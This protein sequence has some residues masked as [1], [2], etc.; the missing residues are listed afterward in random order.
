LANGSGASWFSAIPLAVW[1]MVRS[2]WGI[3]FLVIAFAL[4]S[5]WSRRW[6]GVTALVALVGVV[7]GTAATAD[8]GHGRAAELLSGSPASL[9]GR[10][11]SN[12]GQWFGSP[13]W[14]VLLLGA[15]FALAVLPSVR[16]TVTAQLEAGTVGGVSGLFGTSTGSRGR[17]EVEDWTAVLAVAHMAVL[18]GL[19]VSVWMGLQRISAVADTASCLG[20]PDI[21]VA[22]FRPVWHLSYFLVGLALGV[23]TV[24]NQKSYR[25]VG[26]RGGEQT[27][28]TFGGL[29]GPILLAL[30]VPAG[31][32]LFLLS[33]VLLVGSATALVGRRAAAEIQERRRDERRRKLARARAVEKRRGLR[34]RQEQERRADLERRKSEKEAQGRH[35]ESRDPAAREGKPPAG[36]EC[37]CD[38]CWMDRVDE[39][40]RRREQ[41]RP[42]TE[43][44]EPRPKKDPDVEPPAPPSGETVFASDPVGETQFDSGATDPASDPDL[45]YQSRRPLVDLLPVGSAMHLLLHEDGALSRWHSDRIEAIPGTLLKK[46]LGLASGR[47]DEMIAA[48]GANRLLKVSV[49][50]D[51]GPRISEN[52][53]DLTIG[54]F[55]VNPFGTIVAY[56]PL[57]RPDVFAVLLASGD[58]Q[59][60]AED[61]GGVTALAF[62]TSGHHLAMGL[63]DARVRLF[64]MSTRRVVLELEPPTGV[65]SRVVSL[66]QC[67]ERGWVA[68]CE[69]GR[70]VLWDDAGIV[71]TCLE[72]G[73]RL[74]SLAVCGVSG[75]VAVGSTDGHVLVHSADLDHLELHDHSSTDEVVRVAFEADQRSL[76]SAARDGTVRRVTL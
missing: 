70:L 43:V 46:P 9:A 42:G 61:V 39:E 23:V 76:V 10:F 8:F 47:D 73:H 20:V 65:S 38:D 13:G 3:L 55:A 71:T 56:A 36:D 54:C 6:G 27:G 51:G 34:E 26:L 1:E 5:I 64:D 19:V 74:S 14:G 75:R 17:P 30:V 44:P 45:L 11:L 25:S 32:L 15:V 69:N 62:S 60:L 33:H 12:S 29:V 50:D 31:V 67:P 63:R 49:S 2:G 48:D 58:Q 57:R 72:E 4:G 28:E 53:V 37:G 68:A 59:T 16:R 24:A 35:Q 22:S 18:G 52:R 66:A 7:G 21:T 40:Q 41:E